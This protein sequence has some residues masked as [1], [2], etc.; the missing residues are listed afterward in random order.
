MLQTTIGALHNETSQAVANFFETHRDDMLDFWSKLVSIESGSL[1]KED[2]DKAREF[3]VQSFQSIGGNVRTI[4][5]EKAGDLIIADSFTENGSHPIILSGHYD[6]VFK[7]G[8]IQERPFIIKEDGRAYGPG[9]LDM[10]G[11]I[12]M[13]FFIL[14][15]LQAIGYKSYPVRVVLAGDEEVGHQ[16]ST[17]GEDFKNAVI[18]GRAAF[19]FETGYMDNGF[20]TG[21]KGGARATF[22]CQGI[23]A[24]AGNEPEKGRSAI[25]EIA[26]KVIALQNLNDF[27]AGITYNVGTISGGTVAN[28]VPEKANISVDIRY[29][30]TEQLER[31]RTELQTV[32]DT[33]YIEGTQ[34][35]MDF[36]LS[37][38]PMETSDKVIELFT[39]FKDTAESIGFGTVSPKYVGGG[40]DSA[41]EVEVGLPTLCAVG[42]AGG[43]NHSV[44]EFADVESLFTRANLVAQTILRLE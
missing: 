35:T 29:K 10:K 4:P 5:Y 25:L 14:Q 41:A 32:L 24:H 44:N 1:Y 15:A 9:A 7:H 17:A 22:F 38:R 21:R 6:T 43:K 31:I 34:T 18:G 30:K 23:G 27:D 20:V 2:T 8:T 33:T 19:N 42:V 11:G 40:A 37:L 39:L 28:A 13:L 26:H 3:L 16:F 36:H 12:T